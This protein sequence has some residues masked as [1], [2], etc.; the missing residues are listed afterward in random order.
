[1]SPSKKLFQK[2]TIKLSQENYSEKISWVCMECGY[3]ISMSKLPNS[4]RCPTCRKTKSYFRRKSSRPKNLIVS[5]KDTEKVKWT[6]LG[7]GNE[8]LIDMPQMWKCPLCG[9]PINK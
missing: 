1:M 4:F 5:L 3:E 6:C 9:Y 8:E 7:C 2:K